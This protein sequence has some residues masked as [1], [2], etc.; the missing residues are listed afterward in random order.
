MDG[1]KEKRTEREM[2]PDVWREGDRHRWRDRPVE[3][4]G[5]R[6]VE[7]GRDR[8]VCERESSV[9]DTHNGES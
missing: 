1:E 6:W 5:D 3:W 4:E 8:C 7:G 9:S 2:D